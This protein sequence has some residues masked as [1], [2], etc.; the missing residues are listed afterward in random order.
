MDLIIDPNRVGKFPKTD[1][2]VRAKFRE[3]W[4][5]FDIVELEASSFRSWLEGR[6]DFAIK[7]LM[8]ILGYPLKDSQ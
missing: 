1:I 7:V 5:S 4:G 6:E 8:T 3:A 2:Y